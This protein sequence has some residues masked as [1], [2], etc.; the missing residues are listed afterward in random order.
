MCLQYKRR[1]QNS[2]LPNRFSDN[3]KS[4]AFQQQPSA[5]EIGEE[6]GMCLQRKWRHQNSYLPNRFSN[7]LKEWRRYTA[8]DDCLVSLI[9]IISSLFDITAQISIAASFRPRYSLKF[10]ELQNS[11]RLGNNCQAC[12]IRWIVSLVYAHRPSNVIPCKIYS[13]Y[14]SCSP[15][16]WILYRASQYPI[17]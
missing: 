3:L 2:Q 13:K 6:K 10:G 8:M 4:L 16:V 14:G 11:T 15:T 1:H 17:W 5:G 12:S 9:R 7:N